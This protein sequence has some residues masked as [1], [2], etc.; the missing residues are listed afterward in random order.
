MSTIRVGYSEPANVMGV[1]TM[2]DANAFR[3]IQDT[4]CPA[5]CLV[6]RAEKLPK[7]S[8]MTS[9]QLSS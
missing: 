2:T 6:V 8:S 4:C 1:F 3:I 9:G 7:Q 5:T